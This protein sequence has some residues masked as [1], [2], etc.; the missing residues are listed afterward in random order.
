MKRI[1]ILPTGHGLVF[2][3]SI[4]FMILTAASFNNN[5]V[6]ILSFVLFGVFFVSMIQTN[7]NLKKLKFKNCTIADQVSDQ[8][9][10]IWLTFETTNNKKVECIDLGSKQLVERVGEINQTLRVKAFIPSQKR[11]RHILKKFRVSTTYPLGLFRAWTQ[12]DLSCAYYIYPNPI[13]NNKSSSSKGADGESSSLL[14]QRAQEF[15]DHRAFQFGDNSHH[16]DWKAYARGRPLLIKR[17]QGHLNTISHF[18]LDESDVERS[19]S[20]ITA[21]ILDIKKSQ[22]DFSLKMSATAQPQKFNS[23]QT[24]MA[25]RLLATYGHVA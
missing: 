23:K 12:L 24:A 3:C 10:T 20:L 13:K 11:G 21:D 7:I 25:L 18:V 14:H 4:V 6:Y 9:I 15:Y 8:T 19:L 1:Y 5:L 17:F 22:N 16:I 2:L